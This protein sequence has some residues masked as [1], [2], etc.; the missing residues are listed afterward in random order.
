M[1]KALWAVAV[2]ALLSAII[3]SYSYSAGA[4]SR[5][6]EMDSVRKQRDEAMAG[7]R[8]GL[9]TA[10]EMEGVAKAWRDQALKASAA[11]D[12]LAIESRRLMTNAKACF[13]ELVRE[14]NA[15][16]VPPEGL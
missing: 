9:K 13:V 16:V 14:R 11:Y 2:V 8:A 6:A 3:Q 15:K 7:W 1:T 12:G 4:M 10:N 5:D